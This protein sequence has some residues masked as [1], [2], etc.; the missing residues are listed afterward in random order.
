MLHEYAG[1][2]IA[3][4]VFT[5]LPQEQAARDKIIAA[6]KATF[7]GREVRPIDF[8]LKQE[9]LILDYDGNRD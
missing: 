7:E 9:Y 6:Q 1:E 4:K 8:S 5:A 2:E 3:D